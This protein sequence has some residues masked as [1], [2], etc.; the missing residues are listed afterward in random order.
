VWYFEEVFKELDIANIEEIFKVAFYFPGLVGEEENE[1]MY[2][3][4]KREYIFYFLNFFKKYRI[5]CLGG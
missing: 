2:R 3:E 4:I 1:R 5:S